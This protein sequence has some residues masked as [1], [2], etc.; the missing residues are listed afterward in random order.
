ML[1]P[2]IASHTAWLVIISPV[3]CGIR[4]IF[5]TIS[6]L[7]PHSGYLVQVTDTIAPPRVD[8]QLPVNLLSKVKRLLV[9]ANTQHKCGS[10]KGHSRSPVVA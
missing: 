1:L 9:N 2:I 3:W 8:A 6:L 10:C 5:T 7:V 4:N